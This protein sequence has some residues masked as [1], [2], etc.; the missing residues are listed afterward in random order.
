MQNQ[1]T[2]R[3]R[4]GANGYRLLVDGKVAK[5]SR[6][7][8]PLMEYWRDNLHVDDLS[9]SQE[10]QANRLAGHPINDVSPLARTVWRSMLAFPTPHR[11]RLD[12]LHHLGAKA[13]SH[14]VSVSAGETIS[15]SPST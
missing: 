14:M 6:E 15:G 2:V 1:S 10:F 12:V 5:R 3:V 4:H 9:L 8:W 13:M 7:I 11:C